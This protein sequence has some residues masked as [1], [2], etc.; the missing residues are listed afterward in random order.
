MVHGKIPNLLA[1]PSLPICHPLP[2]G[3]D[4]GGALVEEDPHQPDPFFLSSL[5]GFPV[6]KNDEKIIIVWFWGSGVV[7]HVGECSIYRF[8]KTVQK[9]QCPTLFQPYWPCLNG[10]GMSHI[11]HWV[12]NAIRFFWRGRGCHNSGSFWI[13]WWNEQP[14]SSIYLMSHL[15]P[16]NHL[17]AWQFVEPWNT[18][19]GYVPESYKF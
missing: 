6:E 14:T 13:L 4:F 17:F 7:K 2:S 11:K 1:G 10:L 8:N 5:T 12:A 3:A 18:K 16:R 15:D 9:L 19:I